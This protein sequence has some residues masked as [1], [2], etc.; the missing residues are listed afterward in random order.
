MEKKNGLN[1]AEKLKSK[2]E[3]D[4]LFARRQSFHVFPVRVFYGIQNEEQCDAVKIGFGCSKKYFRHAVRRNRAKR[5]MREAYRTQKHAL[6]QSVA[7]RKKTL[8]IFLLFS[9]NELID[10]AGLQAA[11]FAILQRLEKMI[12]KE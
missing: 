10:Y 1:K 5:L 12:N 11:I 8:H 3:I 2:K 9:N 6:L 4:A 7:E